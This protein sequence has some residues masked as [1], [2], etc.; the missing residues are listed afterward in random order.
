[1]HRAIF[2]FLV[3]ILLVGSQSLHAAPSPETQRAMERITAHI[4]GPVDFQIEPPRPNKGPVIS[5]ATFGA[6]PDATPEQNLAA[7]RAAA[8]QCQE[9]KA[10]RLL[11]PKGRYLVKSEGKQ[12]IELK[13]LSDFTFDGQGAELIFQDTDKRAMGSYLNIVG[14]TRVK[15]TNLVLDW[16]WASHPL[17]SVGRVV[18]TKG[19][20]GTVDFELLDCDIPEGITCMGGREWD[21]KQNIRTAKGF[22]TGMSITKTER[23]GPRR[24]RLTWTKPKL[25]AT[26]RK[27]QHS[28]LVF[29]PNYQVSAVSFD[30]NT[31]L[32]IDRVY[33]YGVYYTAFSGNQNQYYQVVNSKVMPRPGTGRKMA[34]H[35]AFEIHASKGYFRLENNEVY[36][37]HDDGL[38]FSDAFLGGGLIREDDHTLIADK[39]QHYATKHL[40]AKGDTLVLHR[41]DFSPMEW[42]SPIVSFEWEMMYYKKSPNNRCRITFRDPLPKEFPADAMLFNP[43][44]GVGQYVIRNNTFRNGL[45]HG[46]YVCQPNGLIEGNTMQR[47]AYPGLMLHQLIRWKRW[48]MGTNPGNVIIR[49]NTIDGC[50]TAL[51][52]PANLFI[53]SGVDDHPGYVPTPYLVTR[54]VL[55]EGNTI[56]DSPWA[57]LGMWSAKNVVVRNNTFRDSNLAPASYRYRGKGRMFVTN[58]E[59]VVIAGNTCIATKPTYES[60]I[61]IDKATT[62]NVI[63]EG[64][65]G[66]DGEVAPSPLLTPTMTNEEPA[67]GRR[68]RQTAPEYKGT[69]VHHSLYLP[70]DW[71]PG[72][73]YPVIVEYTGNYFPACGSTGKVEGANLGYGIT[74]GKGLI[75]ITMPYIE[76]GRKTNAVTWWGDLQATIDYCKT[77]LPRICKEFGGDPENVFICGFSRGA[78]ATNYIGLADDEIAKL[79][80]GF[81]SHDH[82]DGQRKWSYPNSDPASALVRLK[83]L[84]GRPVLHCSGGDGVKKYLQPHLA[85]GQ[86]TFL[87]VPVAKIFDIPEGK[88]IHP[89]TDLWMNKDSEYRRQARAWLD[90]A[91]RSPR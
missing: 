17:A 83:R 36:L 28:L 18:A 38:H 73:T 55:V 81:F 40:I 1:M 4:T 30:N 66:F 61:Q 67:P 90:A 46:L 57:S 37:N 59:N 26:A 86:F 77:N 6:G 53:G 9:L 5:V 82:Y 76:K 79:W 70:T 56:I 43:R 33:V 35:S 71:K 58:A 52:E 13:G 47:T 24:V 31:H 25:M 75:W 48:F 84:N 60:G 14:C 54:N 87:Q 45:T 12:Q 27:G 7:F 74:G 80:K 91:L 15:V 63:V 2:P 34:S 29:K 11:V 49:N 32:S 22:A 68:V 19:G 88:V 41:R 89:H 16:D 23:L 10:S 85:L 72:G 51:R 69:K 78:I 44:F 8:K 3:T 50:N 39:L 20:P 65:T 62:K 21:P 64:N 42:S